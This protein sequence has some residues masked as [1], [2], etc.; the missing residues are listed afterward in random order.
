MDIKEAA[1]VMGRKGGK[2]SGPRKARPSEVARAAAMKRWR[3]EARDVSNEMGDVF[4]DAFHKDTDG[5]EQP[6]LKEPD[7]I[8]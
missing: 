1:A 2:A 3:P 4:D 6:E 7:H 5:S 8:P